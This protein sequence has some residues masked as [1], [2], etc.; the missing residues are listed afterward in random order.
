MLFYKK[1]IKK[2]Y[3][4]MFFYKELRKTYRQFDIFIV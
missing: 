1:I 2:S 4:S 3:F